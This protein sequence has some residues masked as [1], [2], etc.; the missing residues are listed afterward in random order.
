MNKRIVFCG[1][2]EI[3]S[4]VL[5]SLYQNGYQIE[6]VYTQPPVASHRGQKV[7]KSAVHLISE[8]LNLPVRTPVTLNNEEE[9]NYLKNLNID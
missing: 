9:K 4:Q 1:T 2:P 5:K 7:N 8:N 3:A 6:C